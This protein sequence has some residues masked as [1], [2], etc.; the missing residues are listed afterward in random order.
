MKVL[1]DYLLCWIFFIPP[2]LQ[3][4][5]L[6]IFIIIIT[7]MRSRAAFS[8][9][10]NPN[11]PTS[12][13]DHH[14]SVSVLCLFPIL[15]V[16]LLLLLAYEPSRLLFYSANC[17]HNM[18]LFNVATGN[19]NKREQMSICN[20]LSDIHKTQPPTFYPPPRDR[21]LLCDMCFMYSAAQP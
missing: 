7:W 16:L 9:P 8:Y 17:Q 3:R 20:P 6:T 14:S 10:L 13:T 18:F 1:K 4:D 15:Y 19:E 12:S 11:D 5:S 21:L 2:P